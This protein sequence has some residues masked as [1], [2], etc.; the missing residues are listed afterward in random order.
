MNTRR[1]LLRIAAAGVATTKMN[2]APPVGRIDCQS[3]LFSEE[4]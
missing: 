4:F 3:H 2:A 1:E